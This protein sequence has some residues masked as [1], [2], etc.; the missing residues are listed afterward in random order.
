MS[1]NPII[2]H[3][4]GTKAVI[5]ARVS[6]PSQQ[7]SPQLQ[8]LEEYAHQLGYSEV[9]PFGTT[10]S[11]FLETDDKQGWNLVVDF[12]ETHPDYKVLICTELS[13]LSRL[14]ST[15]FVIRDYLIANNIQLIVK[16]ISFSLFDEWGKVDESRKLVFALYASLSN[17]EMKQK[18]E[19]FKRALKEYKL[20][21]IS[22][23]GKILFGYD[24]CFE[25]IN[26]KNRSYYKVN[27][28]Q[29]EEI[30][31][32][33]R[34][35]AF[36]IDGQITKTSV[37]TI[38]L[39]C[40]ER[41]F[42]PYLHSKRN[43]YKCLNERAYIGLKETQNRIKNP[44][45]WNYKKADAPKYLLGEKYVCTYPPI[46][47]DDD[48][49]LYDI[50]KQRL[51]DNNSKLKL[52]NNC[53]VDK[54]T[55]HITLLSKIITCPKCGRKLCGEYRIRNNGKQDFYYRCNNSRGVVSNCSYKSTIDMKT[56]DS[57]IWGLCKDR[58]IADMLKV[59]KDKSQADEV[60][61]RNRIRNI[62]TEIDNIEAH[63]EAEDT[64]YRNAMNRARTEESRKSATEKYERKQAE[65]Q[66]SQ[67]ELVARQKELYKQI[68]AVI[69]QRASIEQ[70]YDVIDEKDKK[71][72][73]LHMHNL[74]SEIVPLYSDRA[75]LAVKVF[76]NVNHSN[77]SI[78]IILRKR[79]GLDKIIT[80]LPKIEVMD[81]D[82]GEVETKDIT[83][84]EN[85]IIKQDNAEYSIDE[86][87]NSVFNGN[88]LQGF[89]FFPQ[90]LN[91]KQ[92]ECYESDI[93]SK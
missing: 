57:I 42:S 60:E 84:L 38:T 2:R 79:T 58:A 62:Q 29:K 5:V 39:E 19:R 8:D 30:L 55:Q 37:R 13:R 12:F 40:I 52:E 92:L 66:K 41:G 32:I 1:K 6:T 70:M 48:R 4:F 27:Q 82:T 64:I 14:E 36:G 3:N 61:L 83:I 56:I 65:I 16:D 88:R 31:T 53:L 22:I 77:N 76:L 47:E 21:G 49:V 26:G 9:K 15:L 89:H 43:V 24:R 85:G 67:D 78:Y 69:A 54:S 11:G 71:S 90:R 7:S 93:R 63:Y 18:K 34:W 23:G 35:Y 80:I 86:V 73:Y 44:D 72:L 81:I 45:Y 17:S 51:S 46:F 91:C 75:Y 74:I 25:R 10:E 50:V 87:F 68:E 28:K 20:K 59:E 33:Y